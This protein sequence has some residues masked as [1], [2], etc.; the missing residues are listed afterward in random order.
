VDVGPFTN[1]FLTLDMSRNL[2]RLIP[3]QAWS[4]AENMS[5]D[6]ALAESVDATG[7]PVLRF[8][9]WKSPT[10][11]LGYFQRL[12]DRAKHADSLAIDCVRRAT[13]GGAIVHHHEL[14]YS[15]AIPDSPEGAGPRLDLYR[16]T[17]QC[18]VNSLA[19][20][21]VR[22]TPFRSCP[23]AVV[24]ESDESEPF[25]CFQR[26]TAEDL[27]V[28]GYKVLGS[29]QRRTRAAVLQHGSLL[30]TASPWAPQLPGI[31]D[32]SSRVLS[33]ETLVA[34]FAKRLGDAIAVEWRDDSVAR[35]ERQRIDALVSERFGNRR[36]LARR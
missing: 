17:H 2:G 34:S 33:V 5:V 19:E 24:R 32:L 12:A 7:I 8:Y 10:L 36:W 1:D 11:S 28:S 22:A 18:W 16:I 30:L 29:A 15:V 31:D 26:R 25:L 20:Q 35:I 21:G 23:S 13:G 3:L 6:Q 27:I 14:T 4:G 9:L